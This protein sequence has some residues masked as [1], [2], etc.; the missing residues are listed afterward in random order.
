M[1]D[2][3]GLGH[4]VDRAQLSVYCL[5][6]H[7]LEVPGEYTATTAR[8]DE[9]S[10]DRTYTFALHS[11]QVAHLRKFLVYSYGDDAEAAAIPDRITAWMDEALEFTFEDLLDA[12]VVRLDEFWRDCHVDI[13]GDDSL[14]QAVRFALFQVLQSSALAQCRGIP[15]KGLTGQGYSGHY[16][17]DMEIYVLHVLTY[18]SPNQTLESLRYRHS[19]LDQARERARHLSK[20]GALFPWRTINGHEA[21][22]FFPTGTAEYHINGDIAHAVRHYA[23]IT[24]D[25]D[26]LFVE[27]IDILTETARFWLSL[28]FFN[29]HRGGR[30]CINTVTGPDEY[31]ALV[32]NNTYTNLMAQSNMSFAAAVVDRM[33]ESAPRAYVAMVARIGLGEDEPAAWRAAAEAMYIHYDEDRALHGQDDSFLDKQPWDF[34][35]TPPENYPLLLHY[36]PLDLY[37]SQVIKQADLAMAMFLSG[38]AFTAEEK[39]RNFEYYDP[40]TT[41]DSSLSMCIQAIMAAEIGDLEKAWDYTQRTALTDLHNVQ[42]NVHDGIHIA[43]QAG[44]WMA[45]ACGFGGLRN[46]RGV[47]HFR[48]Q[49]PPELKTLGFRCRADAAVVELLMTPHRVSYSLVVGTSLEIVHNDRPIT[50]IA[51][52][53]VHIHW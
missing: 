36:H 14:R 13:I 47:L 15:A 20:E 18:V 40:I 10:I 35:G 34:A 26:F 31:T 45:L 4:R 3:I 37:R 19:T 32:D 33:R 48:P 52:E 1:D 22:S 8:D 23:E 44:T 6:D 7:I 43:S 29:P 39:K 53:P 51:D 16:F 5:T 12:Q 50:L 11:G 30:F 2:R 28:G 38:D 9:S 24:G 49:L 25:D 42:H 21:S 27:G 46:N 17:W 41:A